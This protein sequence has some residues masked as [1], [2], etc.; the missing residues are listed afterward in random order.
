MRNPMTRKSDLTDKILWDII[1]KQAA[2]IKRLRRHR[3]VL[4]NRLAH[5]EGK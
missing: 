1:Y 4:F 5:K 2:Q 3:S